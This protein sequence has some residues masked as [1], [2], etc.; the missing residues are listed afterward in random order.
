MS[1]LFGGSSSSPKKQEPTAQEIELAKQGVDKYNRYQE[2]YAPLEEASIANISRP[3][4]QL[5]EGRTNADLMQEATKT[6]TQSIES[7]NISQGLSSLD[8]LSRGLA[9]AGGANNVNAVVSDQTEKD[10]R[11]LN[12]IATGL[13]LAATEQQ[14]LTSLAANKNKEAEAKLNAELTRSNAKANMRASITGAALGSA[15]K[16]YDTYKEQQFVDQLFRAPAL[17]MN[18]LSDY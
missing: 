16:G 2:R 10:Q 15:K 7:G 1:S 13:G 11:A 5:Q 8:G 14:G 9:A 18:T 17:N 12:N 3:T 4:V 6:A